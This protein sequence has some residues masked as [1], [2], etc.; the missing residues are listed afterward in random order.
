M[1][2]TLMSELSK[3]EFYDVWHQ[4]NTGTRAD[5]EREWDEFQAHMAARRA[6]RGIQ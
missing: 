6:K 3:D 4:F 5:Y 2:M 1:S